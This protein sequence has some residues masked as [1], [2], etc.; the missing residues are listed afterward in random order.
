MNKQ[1]GFTL[2]ELM[3]VVAIIAIL[4]SIAMPLYSDYL[5]RTRASAAAAE[6]S[7]YRS[8]VTSCIGDLQMATGC[9]QGSNGIPGIAPAD[10]PPTSNVISIGSIADGVITATTGATDSGGANLTYILT[11]TVNDAV[12]T[13]A[14]TGTICDPRRGLRSGQ[15]SC[16]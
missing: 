15:G 10:F 8:S 4:A 16:P 9:D 1:S 6:L 12:V 13:W 14:N 3:I 5:S 2:I 11:P 7:G